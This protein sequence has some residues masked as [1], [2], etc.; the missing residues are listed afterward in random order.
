[1]PDIDPLELSKQLISCKSITPKDDGALTL[2]KKTL[3]ELGFVCQLVT[4]EEKGTEP[5]DNLYARLGTE[6]KNLCFAGHTDVVPPGDE[7]EWTS[8]PFTP[9]IR[10]N[11]LY[12]RG[13]C[14]MKVAIACFVAACFYRRLVVLIIREDLCLACFK[15]PRNGGDRLL[16]FWSEFVRRRVLL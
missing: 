4:F 11:F 13:A 15:L 8:P 5:V 2:L 9:T 1:M 16:R 10:N 7:K 3:T 12:G 14:D 6:G